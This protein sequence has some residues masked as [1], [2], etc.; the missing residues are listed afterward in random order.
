M[1]HATSSASDL[2]A[3][4]SEAGTAT[5]CTAVSR[6]LACCSEAAARSTSVPVARGTSTPEISLGTD[7]LEAAALGALDKH[8][9]QQAAIIKA[10]AIPPLV[11]MVKGASASAQASAARALASCTR[12]P[13]S[14]CSRRTLLRRVS[15]SP[16][17]VATS[18]A[19]PA[20]A[21]SAAPRCS[22]SRR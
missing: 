4:L 6:S 21:S 14:P 22:S 7:A 2:L 20:A 16:R 15:T 12:A 3:T 13:C 19:D 10:G 8:V 18:A 1:R 9:S 5:T 17:S 11:A